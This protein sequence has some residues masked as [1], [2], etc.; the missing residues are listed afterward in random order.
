[1]MAQGGPIVPAVLIY[2]GT[3]SWKMWFWQYVFAGVLSLALVGLV[4][5]G[6]LNMRRKSRRYRI[7]TRTIDYEAGVLSRRVE[8]LQLWRV[9][10]I[11]LRQTFVERLLGV[12]TIH[13]YTHDQTDPSLFIR[14]LP[15]SRE[16]FDHLKDACDLARQQR[17]IGVVE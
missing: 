15:A 10:D 8:T 2:E 9:K 17:V 6:I 16:I 1:M 11:E 7:T 13:V 4:W 5:M 12:A 3:P 14:G